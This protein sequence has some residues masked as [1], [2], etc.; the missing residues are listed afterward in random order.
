MLFTVNT[1]DDHLRANLGVAIAYCCEWAQNRQE[2]GKRGAITPLVN[3]MTSRDPNVHRSTALALYHL[4]F[5][6]LNCVTMHAVS[7]MFKL[8]CHFMPLTPKITFVH[9]LNFTLQA[10]IKLLTSLV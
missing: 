4:S 6:S 1:T 7:R 5:Y 10:S 9:F 3:Y 2:F 8:I